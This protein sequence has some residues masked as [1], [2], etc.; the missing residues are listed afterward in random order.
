MDGLCVHMI[1]FSLDSLF[2]SYNLPIPEGSKNGVHP[3]GW[4]QNGKMVMGGLAV[5]PNAQNNMG[6]L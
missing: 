3:P 6:L 1:L 2:P 5:T 4:L